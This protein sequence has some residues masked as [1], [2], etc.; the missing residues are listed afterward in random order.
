MAIRI[1]V[2]SGCDILEDEAKKLGISVIPLKVSFGNEEFLDGVNLSHKEFF[3]KLIESDELPKTS[4]IIPAEYEEIFDEFLS[5]GDE[6]ITVTIGSKFSGCFQSA[7][8]AK[9]GRDGIEIIDSG[10][11]AIGERAIVEL[12]V[13]LRDK[14]LSLKEIA[15]EV[16]KKREKLRILALLDTLVY[17]K[18]GGRISAATAFAGE[19]LSIKPVVTVEDC[20]VV[21]VGKARGSKNANNLLINLVKN[22]GGIDFSMPYSAAYSGLSDELIKKYLNDSAELYEGSTESIPVYTIGA[23][24]GT[25]IGPGAIG[26]TFF[27]AE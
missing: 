21:L 20:E 26:V 2:D 24:I 23:A 5:N 22:C 27:S 12:A 7:N 15:D 16:N 13:R 9:D 4:Q 6:V 10:S 3:E 17:L 8:I 18:K 1:V 25:H 19:I 14:G 11:V